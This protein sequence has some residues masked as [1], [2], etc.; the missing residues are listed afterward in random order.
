[1][2]RTFNK[3]LFIRMT[4]RPLKKQNQVASGGDPSNESSSCS[5]TSN[6]NMERVWKFHGV[7]IFQVKACRK[8]RKIN[9]LYIHIGCAYIYP[10][11]LVFLTS[12]IMYHGIFFGSKSLILIKSYNLE[13]MEHSFG[14]NLGVKTSSEKINVKAFIV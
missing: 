13:T 6:D 8:G 12:I 10:V 1:M 5:F 7:A 4:P 14:I 11:K 9:N 2:H 3:D